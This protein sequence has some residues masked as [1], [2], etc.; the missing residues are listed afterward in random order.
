MHRPRGGWGS[1]DDVL[2]SGVRACARGAFL[3]FL[4][5]LLVLLLFFPLLACAC[6][7]RQALSLH[8]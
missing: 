4:V 1:L 6:R 2:L 3:F 5:L 8:G 7:P